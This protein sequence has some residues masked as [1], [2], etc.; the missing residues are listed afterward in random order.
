M[1]TAKSSSKLSPSLRL[2]HWSALVCRHCSFSVVARHRHPLHGQAGFATCARLT[3]ASKI[4]TS[5][6]MAAELAAGGGRGMGLLNNDSLTRL[7]S[8]SSGQTF[9]YPLGIFN[10]HYINGTDSG[11]NRVPL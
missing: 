11:C 10:T 3:I 4:P 5:E 8:Q 6:I 2:G 9:Q 7:R 1:A